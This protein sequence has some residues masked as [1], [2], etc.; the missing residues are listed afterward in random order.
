MHGVPGAVNQEVPSQDPDAS[1][2]RARD[3]LLPPARGTGARDRP[4]GGF[5]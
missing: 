2:S 3:C 1:R 5:V 4:A